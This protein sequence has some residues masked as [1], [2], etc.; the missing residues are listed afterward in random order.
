MRKSTLPAVAILGCLGS[1][2][3]GAQAATQLEPIIGVW[4]LVGL[5]DVDGNLGGNGTIRID[6]GA[7]GRFDYQITGESETEPFKVSGEWTRA[8][9]TLRLFP[10][11]RAAFKFTPMAFRVTWEGRTL[12]LTPI[13]KD[14][15]DAVPL[16]LER[17]PS[18]RAIG[19]A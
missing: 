2:F 3:S 9:E 5:G 1:A 7:S 6:M 16:R 17:R 14:D 8:E 19:P 4:E 15:R 13:E 18:A 11:D 10:E 12:V